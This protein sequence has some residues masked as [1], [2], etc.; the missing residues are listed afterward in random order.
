[1]VER[2]KPKMNG[3]ANG[4]SNG[5]AKSRGSGN[6]PGRPTL[7]REEYIEQAKQLCALGATDIE[8]AKFFNI[9]QAT[10]Y[11]WKNSYPRFSEAIK[12]AKSAADERVERSL[13]QR[14]CGY[15]HE[16][17]KIF[18]NDGQIIRA[19]T[20]QHYPP[21]ATSM[22]FWL[23]NRNPEQWRDKVVQEHTG[24]DGGAIQMSVADELKAKLDQ[25]V[26][27]DHLKM[28]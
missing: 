16:T 14:A 4:R 3:H 7:F 2:Y 24:K 28:H 11:Y 13:Y 12:I 19:K 6:P 27:P 25:L 20:I 26:V 15:S 17:E 5:S 23:K 8:M 1:M 9:S 22:I 21:D 18:Q 10:F